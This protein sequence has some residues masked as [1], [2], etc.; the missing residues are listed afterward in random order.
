MQRIHSITTNAGCFPLSFSL[1]LHIYNISVQDLVGVGGLSI[2]RQQLMD[3][4]ETLLE[5]CVTELKSA[6]V[7]A[8]TEQL[9]KDYDSG[10]DSE[11]RRVDEA[12]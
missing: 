9:M 7:A 10:S 6:V 12:I 1:S 5:T 11:V 8:G 3:L 2:L 4:K